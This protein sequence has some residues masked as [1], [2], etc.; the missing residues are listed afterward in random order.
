MRV[1]HGPT[2]SVTTSFQLPPDLLEQVRAIARRRDVSMAN[3]VRAAL[4]LYVATQD[5]GE[6]Q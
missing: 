6:R 5:A 3:A 2:A 4:R 1:Q